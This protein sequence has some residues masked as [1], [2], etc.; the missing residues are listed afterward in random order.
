MMNRKGFT[1]IEVLIVVI[2]LGILA[3][4][5]MPQISG[6]Q[7]KARTAEAK[8]VMSTIR[9]L[10]MA[11]YQEHNAWPRDPHTTDS[12]LQ[13]EG[14]K[15]V[16]AALGDIVEET[17]SFFNYGYCH[18][19]GG[20]LKDTAN[21]CYIWAQRNNR[22]P[23]GTS[24]PINE[25]SIGMVMRIDGDGSAEPIKSKY[26]NQTADASDPYEVKY[27]PNGPRGIAYNSF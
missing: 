19:N 8:E 21:K 6:M 22:K 1:L 23:D 15:C 2:I 5:L 3:I 26:F 24:G 17:K 11:Y 20:N 13:A 9:T 14:T 16:E 10:L 18:G 25:R 27:D 12:P 4:L 7:E